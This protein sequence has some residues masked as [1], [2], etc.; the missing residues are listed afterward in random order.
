MSRTR[1]LF[2]PFSLFA[3]SALTIVAIAAALVRSHLFAS[4]PDL[5]SWG[6]TFDLT[7]T[8]PAI[9]WLVMVRS[10]RARAA[11]I[12]PVFV[13]GAAIAAILIP[14]DQQHFLHQLRVVAA[15]LDIITIGLVLR[16]LLDMRRRTDGLDAE[17]SIRRAAHA[18]F[19][20]N[21][22][23][24]A[25]A[26]EIS[27]AYYAL[28]CW[29]RQPAVP[30]D[31]H[32]LTVHQQSGWGSVVA[33]IIVVFAAESVGMHLAVQLWSAKAAWMVTALDIYG[34]LWIIGDY[35]A[36]RLRPTLVRGDTIEIRHGLRWSV[37][38]DRRNIAAVEL[39]RSE[40]EWKRRG[41]LKL[42]LIDEPQYLIRL[43]APVIAI[44]MIG[45]R[46]KIDSIAVRPDDPALF[47]QALGW[48]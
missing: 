20:D 17:A 43:R 47:E 32:A 16:R 33:C 22:V 34:M 24:A 28:F 14:R 6:V 4:N 11:T 1:S 35:H 19:G 15:P 46:K 30:P 42:A 44:G 10:G 8:I 48:A 7:V 27:I 18:A 25:V 13:A 2:N 38:I 21:A 23:G 29:R 31:A 40:A 39:V 37:T 3:L 5:A 9:Y 41:T 45:L 36:L 12:A 26:S